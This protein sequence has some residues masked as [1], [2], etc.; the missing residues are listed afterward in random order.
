MKFFPLLFAA[1]LPIL[2]CLPGTAQATTYAGNGNTGFNGAVGNG[3]LSL[4]T[5][6]S[7]AFIFAFTLGGAQTNFGTNND[8]TIYIDNGQGSGIGTSTAGLTD[9]SDGGRQAVSEYSGTQRS[10]T[11]FGTLLSP[12]FALD[13]SVNNANVYGLVNGSS[14]GFNGGQTIGGTSQGGV[15]YA[16]TVVGGNTVL[17][18]TVPATDLS[19]TANAG[20][21][22]KLFALQVSETGFSSN[23]A[24]VAVTGNL[25]YGNTQTI[26]AVNTFTAAAVGAPEPSTLATMLVGGMGALALARRRARVVG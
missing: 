7:G 18:A 20:A 1:G 6:T 21:S 17:T 10:T 2:A 26:S 11:S 25:G 8:L 24:T 15:T 9:T 14:F 22:L 13:L 16:S 12:Q 5:N 4:T 3:T 23:E 19:L